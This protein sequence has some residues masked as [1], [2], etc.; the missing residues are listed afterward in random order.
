MSRSRSRSVP[1]DRPRRRHRSPSRSRSHGR[2]LSRRSKRSRSPVDGRRRS[3]SR[4]RHHK[5]HRKHLKRAKKEKKKR[6][7][8]NK[9]RENQ[10]KELEETA[11][12]EE[13]KDDEKV[14]PV[15][16][17]DTASVDARSFFE[18]LQRQEA[19]KQPVGT[20]HARGLPVPVS[21]TAISTSDKWE[22]SKAGCGNMNSKHAPVC[23]KCGAMKRMTEWR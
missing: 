3:R 23:N 13:N 15:Q 12:A 18:Q 1:R 14:I 16:P 19:V 8:K 6:H 5:K 22:C 21:A 10:E 17:T 20:V 9:H 11:T 4:K 2:R 7:N